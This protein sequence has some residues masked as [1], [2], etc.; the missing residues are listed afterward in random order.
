L[1]LGSK[2]TGRLGSFIFLSS[3]KIGGLCLRVCGEG[4]ADFAPNFGTTGKICRQCKDISR[5][6]V[7]FLISACLLPLILDLGIISSTPAIDL[8]SF[9]SIEAEFR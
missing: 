9:R 3:W 7:I 8:L 4:C 1:P 2:D 6:F 5:V